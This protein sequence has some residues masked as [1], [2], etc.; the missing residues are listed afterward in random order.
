[1]K[2][3]TENKAPQEVLDI[4]LRTINDPIENSIIVTNRLSALRGKALK[5]IKEYKDEKAYV[6]ERKAYVE[7]RK[8][9]TEKLR[10]WY[11]KET[12]SSK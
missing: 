5:A 8:S 6:E 7:E 12:E 3:N 9:Y 4:V 10:A 11:K 2:Q 1:M